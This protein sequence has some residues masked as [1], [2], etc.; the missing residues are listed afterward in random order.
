MQEQNLLADYV[1]IKSDFIKFMDR[2]VKQYADTLWPDDYETRR[3]DVIV[4]DCLLFI[5]SKFKDAQ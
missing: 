1:K 5:D 2:I 4:R 3:A